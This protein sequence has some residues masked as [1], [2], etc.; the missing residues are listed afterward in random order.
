M[1]RYPD[2]PGSIRGDTSERAAQSMRPHAA[3]LRNQVFAYI[4]SRRNATCDEVEVALRM[5]HQTASARIRELV[6]YRQLADSGLRRLTRSGRTA[7]VYVLAPVR[8]VS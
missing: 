7:R 5:R 1:T 2:E 8:R 6:L 3:R 4:K